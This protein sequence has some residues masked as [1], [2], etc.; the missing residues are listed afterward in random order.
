MEAAPSSS[1][2]PVALASLS[3]L[4][5]GLFVAAPVLAVSMLN[6]PKGFRDFAWGAPLSESSGL[7]LTFSD[8]RVKEFELKQAPPT[9]GGTPVDSMKLF[10]IDNQ[11][12]RV[13]VRYR[14][15]RAH[16]QLVAYLQAQY[17]PLDL[18]P[19]Q[20]AASGNYQFTWRGT[21][22]EVNLTFDVRQERGVLFIESR[23]LAAKF[24][25]YMGGM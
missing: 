6:D 16:E 18:T 15:K 10:S 22:T 2:P 25:D 13:S 23:T 4:C 17:G 8:E 20:I 3:V 5:L 19:G 11:F 24:L 12:A 7:T 9:L 14:G 1:L 21:E